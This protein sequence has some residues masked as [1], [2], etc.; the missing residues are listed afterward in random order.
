MELRVLAVAQRF[1]NL[2]VLPLALRRESL[3][4]ELRRLA[5]AGARSV[6]CGLSGQEG[7]WHFVGFRWNTRRVG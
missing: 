4:G 3:A 6:G 5:E 7:S 2:R 1:R